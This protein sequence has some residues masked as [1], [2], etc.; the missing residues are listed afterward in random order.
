MHPPHATPD[1]PV[2]A[3]E[4]AASMQRTWSSLEPDDRAGA[5]EALTASLDQ[6]RELILATAAHETAL[7]IDDLAPEFARMIGTIRM[8]AGI[9]RDGSWVRAAIDRGW[10]P[11]PGRGQPPQGLIGPAHDVRRMLLPLGP[12]LVFGASNF[13][14]AYGVCGGDTAGALATGCVVVVKEHPAHPATG[15]LLASIARDAL[16]SRD[17]KLRDAIQYVHAEDPA[18]H[19]VA[20]AL[21]GHE[22]IAAIGFTGSHRAGTA[23][24]RL[25]SERPAPIPV[26]AEMGS[27]NPVFVLPGAAA[28]RGE[29]I[30]E[31]LAGSILARVGQQCT[32][33]GL[34]FVGEDRGAI[35]G[36]LAHRLAMA[37]AREMLA[38][39]IRD[40]YESR[41][42]EVARTT[43]VTTLVRTARDAGP[44]RAAPSLFSAG[45]EAFAREESLRREVFGPSA[46]VVEG[47]MPE[48]LPRD[49]ARLTL[50]V[51]GEGD[52]LREF[53]RDWASLCAGRIVVNGVPTGVRVCGAMVHGGPYPATNRPDTSA[54]GPLAMERWC[55]PVCVQGCP[56]EL[57][58]PMLRGG[59]VGGGATGPR[60]VR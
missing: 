20:H 55:R 60:L 46:I 50:S 33:P 58:P 42:D 30:A 31:A 14:M 28:A 7:A 16:E 18:D 23:I 27:V 25:A 17:G 37:P 34:V 57:L 44:R 21:V 56:E 2:A 47:P 43:G 24:A 22:A 8:F 11:G 48:A 5:I 6:S 1:G 12:V 38:P 26:F 40:G 41:L 15:R 10:A 49:V 35:R 51:F 32:R 19:R 39:W 29:A 45:V 3:C 53:L 52:E 4:R 54:V 13:P 9:A 59:G 36:A